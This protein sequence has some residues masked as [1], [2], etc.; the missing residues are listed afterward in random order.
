ML[1]VIGNQIIWRKVVAA[2]AL[3]LSLGLCFLA[4][5][6]QRSQLAV[7][8]ATDAIGILCE[9]TL[10]SFGWETSG[11]ISQDQ[12]TL[13]ETFGSEYTDFLAIQKE[14]GFHL[15]PY[16]GKTVTRYTY[17]IKNY[18]MGSDII[19]ADLLVY[20]QVIIGGDIRASSLD[21]FMSSLLYPDT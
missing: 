19:Y 17:E 12:V 4:G 16:A 8:S 5:H 21:G 3:A 13:P 18:P 2:C 7:S 20:N 9:H 14:A 11:L 6:M 15:T 10:S 1:R